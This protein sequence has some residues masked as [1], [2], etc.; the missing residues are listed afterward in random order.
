[1]LKRSLK[2]LTEGLTL[3]VSTESSPASVLSEDGAE[4]AEVGEGNNL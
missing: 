2:A 4:P 1:M 3:T